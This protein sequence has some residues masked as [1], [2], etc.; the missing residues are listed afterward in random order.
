MSLLAHGDTGDEV[1]QFAEIWHACKTG[2]LIERG[3]HA[4]ARLISRRTRPVPGPPL[5]LRQ[6]VVPE[7][8]ARLLPDLQTG[9]LRAQSAR[10]EIPTHHDEPTEDSRRVIDRICFPAE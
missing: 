7:A 10:L 3:L 1:D 6:R 2:R 8:G 9:P 4:L 5:R